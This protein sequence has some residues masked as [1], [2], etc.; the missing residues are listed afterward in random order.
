VWDQ[1][2][3]QAGSVASPFW[4]SEQGEAH[5]KR[6]PAAARGRPKVAPVRWSCRWGGRSSGRRRGGVSRAGERLKGV[7]VVEWRRSTVRMNLAPALGA[8]LGG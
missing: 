4:A 2:L 3:E 7:G 6:L 1:A 5:R 8:I